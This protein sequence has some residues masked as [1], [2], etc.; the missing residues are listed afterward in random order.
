MG[1][2]KA[3]LSLTFP[4][5][6]QHIVI[7]GFCLLQHRHMKTRRIGRR[8]FAR[9]QLSVRPDFGLLL[10]F[11]FR[12]HVGFCLISVMTRYL[13]GEKPVFFLNAVAPVM[14]YERNAYP[15]LAIGNNRDMGL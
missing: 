2:R 4:V 9:P 12:R 10:F 15:V 1:Q 14:N 3:L 13:I 6:G 7:L 11:A 5:D 8:I